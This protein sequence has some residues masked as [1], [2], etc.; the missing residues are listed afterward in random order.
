MTGATWSPIRKTRVLSCGIFEFSRRAVPSKVPPSFVSPAGTFINGIIDGTKCPKN[1]SVFITRKLIVVSLICLYY[2][3][4][5]WYVANGRR[6]QHHD[7]PWTLC[8]QEPYSCQILAFGNDGTTIHLHR[9]RHRTT[10]QWVYFINILYPFL[11]LTYI[12][13]PSLRRAYRW[14]CANYWGPQRDR[15]RCGLASFSLR[16]SEQ[17]IRF[18]R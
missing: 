8:Q 13:Q 5:Q 17:F 7:L 16:N 9:L 15:S 12:I 10:S 14:S 2:F 4:L 11:R 3:S 6:H 1:V 18:H